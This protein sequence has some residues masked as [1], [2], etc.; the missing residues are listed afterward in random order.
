MYTFVDAASALHNPYRTAML[1]TIL[2]L[3]I[4]PLVVILVV[5]FRKARAPKPP[6]EAL[7]ELVLLLASPRTLTKEHLVQAVREAFGRDLANAGEGA[8]EF[9]ASHEGASLVTAEGYA[10]SLLASPE[11]Y[12]KDPETE[13]EG[14]VELRM[15][16]AFAEHRATISAAIVESPEGSTRADAYDRLGRL[17]AALVDETTRLVFCP[18]TRTG[19]L[20]TEETLDGLR[21]G[22]PR[23]MMRTIN[24]NPIGLVSNEDPRMAA[25]TA[26][27]R[28]R[29]PE[30]AAAFH[31]A[32]DRDAFLVKGPFTDGTHTEFM[33]VQPTSIERETI[34]GLLANDP[35]QVRGLRQGKAVAIAFA[36]VSDWV[37]GKDGEPV[38]MFTEAIVRGAL[39]GDAP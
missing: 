19:N 35:F 8:E 31:A 24:F 12:V 21:G 36:D 7:P 17:V 14:I 37:Y 27:A 15:K 34:H 22:D 20:L 13:S 2:L 29:L 1:P 25:A 23:G 32:E 26:E 16:I 10:F 11:P 9:V 28:R 18:E 38:G 6:E 5:F 30:F 3:V 33:W 39:S 4:V